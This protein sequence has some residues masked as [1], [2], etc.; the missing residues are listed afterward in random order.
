M[1]VYPR[2]GT[3]QEPDRERAPGNGNRVVLRRVRRRNE[4]ARNEPLRS[5]GRRCRPS[6]PVTSRRA[7]PRV[8]RLRGARV[9]PAADP[10]RVAVRRAHRAGQRAGALRPGGGEEPRRDRPAA[11]ILPADPD[12]G[13]RPLREQRGGGARRVPLLRRGPGARRALSQHP[14]HELD[15]P[16]ARRVPGRTRGADAPGR[17]PRRLRDPPGGEPAGVPSGGVSRAGRGLRAALV[18]PGRGHAPGEPGGH[19]AGPG[20]RRRGDEPAARPVSSERRPGLRRL[21]AGLSGGALARHRRGAPAQPRGLRGRDLPA[22][23][24]DGRA[25]RRLPLRAGGSGALRRARGEPGPPHLRSRPGRRGGPARARAARFPSCSAARP[26]RSA[27]RRYPPFIL[28]PSG[29]CPTGS[30]AAVS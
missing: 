7:P 28:S 5:H 25:V 29:S 16:G 26:G 20:Y 24:A 8:A 2:P 15:S 13:A 9:H 27:S 19:G 30:W 4:P 1:T 6:H 10:R 17:R 18:R 21:P 12:R 14:G 3:A 22:R 11:R 23:P